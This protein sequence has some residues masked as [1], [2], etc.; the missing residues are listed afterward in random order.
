MGRRSPGSY[1]SDEIKAMT[2]ERVRAGSKIVDA[3]REIGVNESLVSKWTRTATPKG[4]GPNFDELAP[5]R[6]VGGSAAVTG[7][8]DLHIRPGGAEIVVPPGYPA[9]GLTQ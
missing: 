5:P 3:A 1:W 6:D 4:D 9:S 8:A 2:A 7:N